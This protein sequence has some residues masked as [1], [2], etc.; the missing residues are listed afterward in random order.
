MAKKGKVFEFAGLRF[1]IEVAHGVH[2]LKAIGKV[3]ANFAQQLNRFGY[4]LFTAF[5]RLEGRFAKYVYLRI[6]RA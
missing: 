6:P 4:E 2:Y 5:K 1:Q 3:R